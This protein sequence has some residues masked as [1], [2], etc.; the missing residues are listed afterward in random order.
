MCIVVY[1]CPLARLLKLEQFI[2]SDVNELAS[3]KVCS[4]QT[5]HLAWNNYERGTDL[6]FTV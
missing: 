1:F 4:S 2:L 5:L 3:A 6:P